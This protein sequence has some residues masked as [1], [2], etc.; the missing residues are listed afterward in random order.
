MPRCRSVVGRHALLN[1]PHQHTLC[2]QRQ[3][4]HHPVAGLHDAYIAQGMVGQGAAGCG[5]VRT[6][7]WQI[8]NRLPVAQPLFPY[9]MVHT[10][11]A[12]KRPEDIHP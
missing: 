12:G 8:S 9:R 1:R 2:C 5:R 7:L 4:Q 10:K 6:V 3:V 11:Q